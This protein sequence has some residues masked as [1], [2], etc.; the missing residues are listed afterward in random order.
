MDELY[1]LLQELNIP[2]AYHHFIKLTAPPFITYFRS[3]TDN[4][5]ADNKVYQKINHFRIE[6]YTTQKDIELE[7]R[8]EDLLD[9]NKFPYEVLSESYI[10]SEKVYQLIYEINI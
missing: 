8:L 2:I 7:A 4:F 9:N 10:E 5:Y 1:E 6:L 3:G